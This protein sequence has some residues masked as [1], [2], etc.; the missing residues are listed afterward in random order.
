MDWPWPRAAG[1]HWR[2]LW[3]CTETAS[4][5]CG[6]VR[7]PSARAQ[8]ASCSRD[9]GRGSRK[10]LRTRR[11][12]R[13]AAGSPALRQ[14]LPPPG[15]PCRSC[16]SPAASRAQSHGLWGARAWRTRERSKDDAGL[17]AVGRSP[18]S[19]LRGLR[20]TTR[21]PCPAQGPAD[22]RGGRVPPWQVQLLERALWA[23]GTQ[24]GSAF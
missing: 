9:E 2:P 22:Q 19:P 16:W 21:T 3:L 23:S 11:G 4:P 12:G 6:G 18:R 7:A 10:V 5:P 1:S 17:R 15:P 20:V 13:K 14:R 24:A 8:R